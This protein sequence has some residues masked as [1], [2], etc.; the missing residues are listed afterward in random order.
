MLLKNQKVYSQNV[1]YLVMRGHLHFQV[2]VILNDQ[3]M[4]LIL[5]I[6]G[7]DISVINATFGKYKA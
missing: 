1:D 2:F 3:N 4:A 6:Y 7:L 5:M